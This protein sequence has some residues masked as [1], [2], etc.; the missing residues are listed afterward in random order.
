MSLD[1]L[2][3]VRKACALTRAND[4]GL[5]ALSTNVLRLQANTD[6]T[7]DQHHYQLLHLLVLRSCAV[8]QL[9]GRLPEWWH[10]LVLCYTPFC[11]NALTCERQYRSQT[12]SHRPVASFEV[13]TLSGSALRNLILVLLS[14]TVHLAQMPWQHL[15][16][17]SLAEPQV[18]ST[19][20]FCLRTALLHLWFR[21]K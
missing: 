9:S 15:C 1:L 5:L 7:D 3:P 21:I 17:S 13:A 20:E 6:T 4:R 8:S 11:R 16:T 14:V 2:V 12:C 10:G 19:L 18:S